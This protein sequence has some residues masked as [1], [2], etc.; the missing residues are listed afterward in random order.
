MPK[1]AL[2]QMA[3]SQCVESYQHMLQVA[4]YDVYLPDDELRSVLTGIGCDT[5]LSLTGLVEGMGYP[6]VDC[7]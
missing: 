7:Q 2:L 3:D 5:V 6:K 1:T 4:G